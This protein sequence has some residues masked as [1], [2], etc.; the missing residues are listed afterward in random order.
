MSRLGSAALDKSTFLF[1]FVALLTPS[2]YS[3]PVSETFTVSVRSP[4]SVQRG[5]TA[6]LPCWRSSSQSAEDLEV[7]WYLGSDGFDTP[8]MLYKGKAFDHTSQKASYAGRVSFGLKEATSGGLKSGDVSLKLENTTIKDAGTYTCFLS[9][10]EDYDSAAVSLT[11]T[12]TGRHP[13]LSTVIKDDKVNISCESEG[14]YP[15]PELHWSDGIEALT[16]ADVLFDKTSKGLYSVH[17]WLLLPSMSEVSC[18]VGLPNEMPK[19][20]KMSITYSPS[21]P[22]ESGSSPAGW[23]AFGILLAAVLAAGGALYFRNKAKKTKQEN[24]TTDENEP[25][26]CED[27]LPTALSEASKHYVNVQLVDTGNHL[28]KMSGSKV[29]DNQVEFPDGDRVTC[30]TAVRGSPGFSS[31]RHYWEVSLVPLVNTTMP[32]K[33]SWWIGVTDKQE[34]PKDQSF[35]LSIKNGFWFLFS[36]PDKENSVQFNSEPFIYFP[37]QSTLKTVGVYLDNDNGELSF[38]NVEEKC[39]IASLRTKFTGEMFPLFNP[40]KGDTSSMEIILRPEQDQ[41]NNSAPNEKTNTDQGQSKTS[42]PI[43]KTNTDQGQSK[44]SAPNEKTNTDQGQSKTSAPNEKTNTDQGQSKTSAPIEE[45]NT[46]QDQSKTSAPNENT[47][48]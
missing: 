10:T 45:T 43:E 15:K 3:A 38:Y 39:L 25:L 5:Q 23:V 18:F 11:V 7:R 44:T 35:P 8:V 48:T 24:D 14:W 40:G 17:S 33:K 27:L 9:S 30:L 36:R 29:R 2:S 26:L 21:T 32:P 12:E 6:I 42:A 16:P 19:E 46:E 1:C 20:A 13:L 28:I 4:I 47:N 37:F 34:I 31:G 22:E 41:S